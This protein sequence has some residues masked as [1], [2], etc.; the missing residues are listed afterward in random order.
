MGENRG[1]RTRMLLVAAM[2]LIIAERHIRQPSYR[3][4]SAA[5]PGHPGPHQRS[6]AFSYHISK[7]RSAAPECAWSARM[8]CSLI[9]L[10]L[11]ALMTTSDKATIEDAGVRFLESQR[12]R[13]LCAWQITRGTW[14]RPTQGTC[15]KADQLAPGPAHSFS[16]R[17]RPAIWSAPIVSMRVPSHPLYFGRERDGILLGYVISGFVIGPD[18]LRQIS[19]ATAVDAVFLSQGHSLAST[20]DESTVAPDG[21]VAAIVPVRDLNAPVTLK[22]GNERFIAATRDLASAPGSAST[23]R[24]EVFR[25][26]RTVHP[27]DRSARAFRRFL[28][29]I[30]GT[31][32]DD[33]AFQGRYSAA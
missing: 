19:Q 22:L 24:V 16:E 17:R 21:T 4:S 29:L 30:I 6:G 2:A 28:A 31:L 9:C 1:I 11:K 10:L 18:L 20:L 12:K 32:V 27:A 7:S 15:A 14:L 25:S 23:C 8:L 13:S 26:G 3:S 33:L 5:E